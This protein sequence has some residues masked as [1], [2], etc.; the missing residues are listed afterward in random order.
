MGHEMAHV[1]NEHLVRRVKTADRTAK[2]LGAGIYVLAIGAGAAAG[3]HAQNS[4]PSFSPQTK[5]D[6]FRLGNMMG[7]VGGGVAGAFGGTYL[8]KEIIEGYEQDQELEADEMGMGYLKKAGYNRKVAIGLFKRFALQEAQ[9][10]SLQQKERGK[11]GGDR[12]K[13]LHLM[14]ASPGLKER[15]AK[16]EETIKDD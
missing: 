2:V 4:H 3:V 10:K 16:M 5:A 8:A 7:A 1:A 12:A 15:I 6:L 11:T 13:V 9:E 14:S